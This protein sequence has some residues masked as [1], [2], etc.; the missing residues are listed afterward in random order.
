MHNKELGVL[1]ERALG[2]VTDCIP[3]KLI[4]VK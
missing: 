3:K 4:R 2:S 1:A